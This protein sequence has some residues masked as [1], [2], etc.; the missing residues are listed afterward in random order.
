MRHPQGVPRSLSYPERPL[1]E[2]LENSAVKYPWRPA[3]IYYGRRISYSKLWEQSLRVASTLAE[4][5]LERGD[6]VALMLPN[7]PQ[8]IIAY[9]GILAAG[10][11]AAPLNPLNPR[12]E[13]QREASEL[14]AEILIALDRF[15]DKLPEGSW[16]IYLAEAES[17]LP[18]HLR[19]L[20]HLR[21]RG[22]REGGDARRFRELL[23][24]PPRRIETE[25]N[26]REDLAVILYTGG[27][28]GPPR[29]VMHTH[30]SLMANALQTYHW[31]RGWWR[32]HK[33]YPAGWPHVVSA[34]PFFHSYGL[35]VALHEPLLA[36]ATL[37]LVPKP[38]AEE[39]MRAIQRYR[40]THLP[41][42]PRMIREIANHPRVGDYDLGSLILSVT[43]GAPLEWET[44]ERFMEL[45]GAKLHHGY[46]LT[47]AGP[48]THC[49]PVDREPKPG[50]V[51]FP[52]PDT[53]FR[54]VDLETGRYDV[55]SGKPGELLVRGPQVMRGYW[56][57]PEETE[58]ALRDGWLYTGDVAILDGEGWLRILGRRGE[59]IVAE[60]HALWP[61]EVEELLMSHPGVEEAAV[62]G[63]ADPMRCAM[64]VQALI[65]P[66]AGYMG[67][68]LVSSL[69]SLCREHLEAYK[70][71]SRI[72]IVEELPKTSLGKIDRRS[73][74]RLLE[75]SP[76]FEG[77]EGE[78]PYGEENR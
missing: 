60:G 15:L 65:V 48:V 63:V 21:R 6:R 69:L 56:R 19:V 9:F 76:R 16:E 33:P 1:Y 32:C 54:I 50:S 44:A 43:G 38:K 5:G 36:G 30:Y 45:T 58:R 67:R 25:I 17:Y 35:T 68:E 22:L 8:F 51:G 18:W 47:E 71:P 2:I 41:A 23:E 3:I 62:V 70:V 11:V 49:T 74:R 61:E 28:M 78:G 52:L 72:L 75:A 66:R 24:A 26:P 10:C 7:I 73:V 31:T 55:P 64:D 42:T 27:T 13:I 14:E 29:G 46:G 40:A 34:I 39:I 37:I 53:E 57:R 59:R 20:S 12:E 4:I 77:G